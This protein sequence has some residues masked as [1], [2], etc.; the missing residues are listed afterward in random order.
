MALCLSKRGDRAQSALTQAEAKR[1][2]I[3]HLN[4]LDV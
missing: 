1:L 2:H 4:I 3:R